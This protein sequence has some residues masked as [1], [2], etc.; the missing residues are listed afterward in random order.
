[1]IRWIGIVAATLFVSAQ[2]SQ[3]AVISSGTPST[4]TVPFS[5]NTGSTTLDGTYSI[6]GSGFGTAT[7][8]LTI[9][10]VNNADTSSERL[11]AFG[12]GVTPNVAA[13][14]VGFID[15]A[16]GGMVNASLGANFPAF[17]DVEVCSFGGPNCAGGGGGG[18]DGAGGSDTFMVTLTALAGTTWGTV[19]LDPIAFK[20]QTNYG[21]FE[22][23]PTTSSTTN[24][25]GSSGVP[26]PGTT[27][28]MLLGAGALSLAIKRRR[29]A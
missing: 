10:L 26:E 3:A 27:A 5:F 21:S 18:I 14:G 22:F 15:A 4:G 1:M 28:L 8:T 12:F 20:F 25:G 9:V 17:Q 24:S 11:T 29:A 2:T 13:N 19:T 16:D 7:L 6:T 23:G